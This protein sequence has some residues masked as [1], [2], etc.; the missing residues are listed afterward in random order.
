MGHN[1]TRRRLTIAI[2]VGLLA[3]GSTSASRADPA[4]DSEFLRL[5]GERLV[6]E[7]CWEKAC[8]V[9]G[10]LS[11]RDPGN[12]KTHAAYLTCLRHVLLIRRYEDPSV[13]DLVL[14]Q[15]V[16]T[17]EKM[18]LEVIE[19]LRNNYADEQ[20]TQLASL[21][22]GGLDQLQLALNDQLFR[23]RWIPGATAASLR[24]FERRL[25]TFREPRRVREH[26]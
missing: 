9:Y 10:E 24:D 19:K 21:F 2:L 15:D 1:P 4:D 22:Q 13:I 14:R 3:L 6:A 18:Y 16:R 11:V 12:D 23:K 26:A 20:K 8:E 7:S 5:L 25:A 17:L